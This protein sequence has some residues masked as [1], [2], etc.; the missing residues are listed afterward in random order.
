MFTLHVGGDLNFDGGLFQNGSRYISSQWTSQPNTSNIYIM[1]ANIG[2]GTTVPQFALHVE[3]SN[4]SFGSNLFVAGTV[5]ARGSFV[6]TSDQSLKTNLEPIIDPLAKLNSLHGYTYDRTDTGKK[7]TGLIA[8]DVLRIL[9]EVVSIDDRNL[10]T[11]AYGNM[12][13]LFVEGFKE[14]TK[15]IEQMKQEIAD[16]RSQLE[17][18]SSRI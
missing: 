16:L 2:I 18:S 14:L 10:L 3:G 12:A 7:D 8:Q 13:G 15:Q 6:S 1:N 4:V 9:P 5:Y 11:I 17:S